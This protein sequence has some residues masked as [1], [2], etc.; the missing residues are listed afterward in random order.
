MIIIASIFRRYEVVL[1]HADKPVSPIAVFNSFAVSLRV[2]CLSV[3]GDE[4]GLFEEA[5]K[6]SRG[7]EEAPNVGAERE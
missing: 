4:R 1:E 7:N 2:S 5:I 3:A 6:L